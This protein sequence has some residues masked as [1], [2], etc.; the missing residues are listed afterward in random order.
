MTPDAPDPTS[1]LPPAHWQ[2]LVAAW[3]QER[4]HFLQT[5]AQQQQQIDTLL[6]QVKYL[7]KQLHGQK[8]ERF[9]SV[10]PGELLLPGFLAG[11]LATA[12]DFTAQPPPPASNPPPKPAG[13]TAR[14]KSAGRP[15][16][17]FPPDC[18]VIQREILPAEVIA[19][20]DAYRKIR[21]AE[22]ELLHITPAQF[23]KLI[24]RR[25]VFVPV[26]KDLTEPS[27]S[28]PI[29]APLATLQ[30]DSHVS[31]STLAYIITSKYADHLPFYRQEQIYKTRH[32]IYLPRQT[33]CRWAGMAHEV[34]LPGILSDLKS[35]I[36]RSNFLHIDETPIKY[37]CPGNGQT[38]QGYLWVIHAPGIG[39]Y[40]HWSTSRGA[41][42]LA[43]LLPENWSGHIMCDGYAVYDKLRKDRPKNIT[44]CACLAHV[45][46]KFYEAKD[47][48]PA[49]TN[50]ILQQIQL[51]YDIEARLK[52]D[53]ASP[54]Q[55]K[56]RREVESQP[57][58]DR[59][60]KLLDRYASQ[61]T[62]L[63]QSRMGQAINYALGQWAD[64]LPVLAH[65]HL[66]IDNNAVEREIRPTAVGKKNYLFFGPGESGQV[67]A[68]YYSLIATAKVHGLDPFK[69][70]E[71]L[72]EALPSLVTPQQ[73]AWL[74]A[75]YV[76]AKPSQPLRY[77]ETRP[78]TSNNT[79]A[80]QAA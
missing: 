77:T 56:L 59:L 24:I 15:Q 21:E 5:I 48:A 14:K 7:N 75:A 4:T 70:L 53:R 62:H 54:K 40:Y 58:Y 3:E 45:R 71:D 79:A 27:A 26:I 38:K 32:G 64:L 22:T 78:A 25:P 37:L 42:V 47:H 50:F 2:E 67:S 61:R 55:I 46:R 8:S 12:A 29:I 73:S 28:A 20:P 36:L 44:L 13:A 51:L 74:P 33:M 76:K 31:A 23:S 39:T 9:T 1:A 63:P 57:I 80:S 16:F 6:T 17:I 68:G 34:W 11:A 18:P 60:K 41:K 66:P 19:Q 65:G 72:F 35:A 49:A 69:Y 52:A 43:E 30:E 10:N